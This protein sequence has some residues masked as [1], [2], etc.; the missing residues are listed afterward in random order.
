MH[1]CD[2]WYLSAAPYDFLFCCCC[3]WVLRHFL[4][5]QVISIASDIEREKSDKF[6][7]EAPISAWGSFTCRKSTTRY[8]STALLPF[9]RK[10][11]A[12]FLR[13]E[14]PSTPIGFEPANLGSSGEYFSFYMAWNDKIMSANKINT[15]K[16]L[17]RKLLTVS[18][19]LTLLTEEVYFHQVGKEH[20]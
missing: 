10:T 11:Y 2:Q 16:K 12:G 9:Q 5:S 8:P 6:S 20:K 14:N 15:L 3:C 18:N 13:S 4:T 19:L 7:S 17:Y 1:N